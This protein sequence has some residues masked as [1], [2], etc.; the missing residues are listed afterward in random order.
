MAL[1]GNFNKI[2]YTPHESETEEVTVS[3]PAT[4]DSNHPDYDKRGTSET[5]TQPTLVQSTVN[6]PTAYIVVHSYNGWKIEWPAYDGVSKEKDWVFT[7][8]LRIYATKAQRDADYE[9]YTDTMALAC[10][11]EVF[12]F[13]VPTG[14]WIYTW[15]KTQPE[16]SGLTDV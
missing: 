9:N 16:F 14:Q 5:V 12:D 10:G 7:M 6:Y 1:T 13:T 2:T 15:L 4:M 3:Y 11:A 8:D